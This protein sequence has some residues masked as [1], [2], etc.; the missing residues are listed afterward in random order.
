MLMPRS[1]RFHNIATR[2]AG[3][4]PRSARQEHKVFAESVAVL[5]QLFQQQR[6]ERR[7]L[8]ERRA[9]QQRADTV[10]PGRGL[11]GRNTWPSNNSAD[12]RGNELATK[13]D[14]LSIIQAATSITTPRRHESLR[15]DLDQLNS[16]A[17]ARYLLGY[18]ANGCFSRL[19][20]RP[21]VGVPSIQQRNCAH[22]R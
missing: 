9:R 8:V 7:F 18:E 21:G 17:F 10:G 3:L 22:R 20:R 1:F 14:G 11:G 16:D 5:L 15:Q 2:R 12:E 19:L 13:H 4:A 6:A